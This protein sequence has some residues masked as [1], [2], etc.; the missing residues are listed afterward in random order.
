MFE[1]EIKEALKLYGLDETLFDKIKVEKAEQVSEAVRDFAVN[2]LAEQK[3][4]SELDKKIKEL[5]A[6]KEKFIKAE[7]ERIEA[8]FK[9]KNQHIKPEEKK[10]DEMPSWMK[11][12]IEKFEMQDKKFSELEEKERAKA[13]KELI[14]KHL[15]DSKLPDK[16]V[17]HITAEDEAGI[18]EQIDTFKQIIN[19]S[20]AERNGDD[21]KGQKGVASPAVVDEIVNELNSGQGTQSFPG[22]NIGE[23][24]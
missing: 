10:Q 5:E 24:K 1:K 14:Q 18:K 4:K 3:A 16:L 12:F 2:Y 23:I 9:A 8:E 22:V 19:D 6:E 7:K 17:M 11:P 20:I 21:E 13:R 15:S